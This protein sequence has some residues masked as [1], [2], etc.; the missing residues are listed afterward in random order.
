[1][2]NGKSHNRRR[3]VSKFVLG[4]K[5]P[6]QRTGLAR[7]QDLEN[8]EEE[9]EEEEEKEEEEGEEQKK[10]RRTRKQR[11]INWV[12]VLQTDLRCIR[13]IH[14]YSIVFCMV[15]CWLDLLIRLNCYVACSRKN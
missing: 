8:D 2:Q 9:E 12:F 5:R 4:F 11:R 14:Y 13:A 1:M 10:K 15:I 3:R 6:V 7:A